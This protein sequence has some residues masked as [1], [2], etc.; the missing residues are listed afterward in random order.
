MEDQP[1]I[2]E[3]TPPAPR[4]M[5]RRKRW[6]LLGLLALGLAL[7]WFS[8]KDIADNFIARELADRGIPATYKVQSVGL[9]RQVLADLV[10]GD[11]ARPDFTAERIEVETANA[12][13]LPGLGR[14][15]LVRPRLYGTLRD[16]KVSFGKLDPLIFTGSDEPPQLPD[17]D[18][19]LVDGRA[20]IDSDFGLIGIKAEGRGR[21]PQGF[22]GT[23]AAV[24]PSLALN[25]CAARGASLYAQVRTAAGQP[26]FDGPLRLAG[27]DCAGARLG[28]SAVNLK[29]R[30]DRHFDGAEGRLALDGGAVT[31]D[32][33]RLASGK[34]KVRF[35]WRK[36][37][38]TAHYDLDAAR[39]ASPQAALAGLSAKGVLRA[40]DDFSRL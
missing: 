5:W 20:R 12:W 23:L 10:I 4:P 17:L 32:G 36:Q 37:A 34:G 22:A 6:G 25:G 40:T 19:A 24:A 18:I 9:G 38:L 8:R 30:L 28:P 16:G 26:S 35:V 15:T 3:Q 2:D 31:A 27:L 7:A 21:L 11:P 13:G 1:A 29:A 14:I 39:L 33:V